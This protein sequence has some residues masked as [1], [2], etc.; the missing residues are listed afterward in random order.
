M[1]ALLNPRMWLAIAVAALLAGSH[2]TA[3]RT[4]RA[5]VAGDWAQER[6][7]RAQE[8]VGAEIEARAKEQALTQKVNDVQ[9]K[10]NVEKK[11]AAASAGAAAGE[12]RLLQEALAASVAASSSSAS[13]RV[14]GAGVGGLFLECAGKYQGVAAEAD[15]IA[16]KLTGLQ[17]YVTQVCKP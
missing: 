5:L 1:L 12:L 4:G 7:I 10:L 3:Y 13:A 11:R 17:S 15:S 2:F 16:N 8:M 6:A 14:D 9:A